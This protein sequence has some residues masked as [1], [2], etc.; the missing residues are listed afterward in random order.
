[1]KVQELLAKTKLEY[2]IIDSKLEIPYI[3]LISQMPDN[4]KEMETAKSWI[5]KMPSGDKAVYIYIGQE[6]KDN[7]IGIEEYSKNHNITSITVRKKIRA[8]NFPAQKV[9]RDWLIKENE[10]WIDLRT[11]KSVPSQNAH[12][13]RLS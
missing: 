9:G 4:V 1:M 10:P 5:K 3:G 12:P 2:C 6:S 11:K 7:L 13:K 8:G